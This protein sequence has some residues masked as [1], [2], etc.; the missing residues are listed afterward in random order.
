MCLHCG[1][2]SSY[3][4]TC[5]KLPNWMLLAKSLL[6]HGARCRPLH[7]YLHSCW[8]VGF[9]VCGVSC[10]HCHRYANVLRDADAQ[11]PSNATVL[12][13]LWRLGR[14]WNRVLKWATKILH[15]ALNEQVS[16]PKGHR[17]D[18]VEH[19]TFDNYAERWNQL[20][21]HNNGKWNNMVS[22]TWVSA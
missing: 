16:E 17:A 4:H 7:E 2:C 9:A 13:L 19:S 22:E 15:V 18:S 6:Q 10:C 20:A 21:G 12:G 1:C 3:G 11:T 8:R 14:C 5:V